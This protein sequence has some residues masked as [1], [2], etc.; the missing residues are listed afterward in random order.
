MTILRLD[1]DKALPD[2]VLQSLV[3][4]GFKNIEAMA[5][6]QSGQIELSLGIIG[7][8]KISLP[9]LSE[10]QRIVTEI[11]KIEDE[12]SRLESELTTIPSQKEFILKKYLA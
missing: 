2:F 4:I 5:T 11:E 3:K 12:I 9:P 1:R 8:I 10:Q 7:N 6:G